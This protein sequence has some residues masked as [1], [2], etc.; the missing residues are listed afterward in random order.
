MPSDSGFS[1]GSVARS[2]VSSITASGG[3]SVPKSRDATF[4]TAAARSAS[5]SWLDIVADVPMQRGG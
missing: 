1:L 5:S 4:A 3:M 2:S